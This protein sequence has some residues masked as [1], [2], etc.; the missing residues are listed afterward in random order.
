MRHRIRRGS[1]TCKPCAPDQSCAEPCEVSTLDDAAKNTSIKELFSE[2]V[3]T[4]NVC[5]CVES[6][7]FV[8][9]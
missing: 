9:I 6:E 8:L 1:E 2:T 7:A 4:L 3:V 5:V